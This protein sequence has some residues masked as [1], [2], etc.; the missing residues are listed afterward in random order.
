MNHPRF[1]YLLLAATIL[2]NSIAAAATLQAAAGCAPPVAGTGNVWYIDSV[3]GTALGDGSQAHPWNSLAAI[4]ETLP[5]AQAAWEPP[6]CNGDL[7]PNCSKGPLL[8]TTPYWHYDPALNAYATW[9]NPNAPIKS[10]DTILLMSGYYGDI[11]MSGAANTAFITVKPVPG[12]TPV[13]SSLN[14]NGS[15]M[16]IIQGLTFRSLASGYSAFI[17]ITGGPT[18]GSSNNII[19]DSNYLASQDNVDTWL[20]ADWNSYARFSAISTNGGPS[21][22]NAQCIAI[23]NNTIKNVRW[24]VT[25]AADNELVDGNTI[26]H[27]GDDAIDY[28]ANNLVISHNTITNNLNIGD[29]NHND[30]MQGQPGYSVA[31]TTLNNVTINGNIVIAQTTLS[32]PFPGG[33]QGIDAFDGDWSNMTVINNVVITNATHGMSFYRLHGGLIANNTVLASGINGTWLGIFDP[34]SNNV[35]VRNN[36]VSNIANDSYDPTVTFDHNLVGTQIAWWVTGQSQFLSAPGTYGNQNVIDPYGLSQVF[37]SYNKA[38]LTYDVHLLAG[39]LAVG[40]GNSVAPPD[41]FGF[42][43]PSPVDLGVFELVPPT[44]TTTTTTTTTSTTPTTT[45]TPSP[46]PGKRKGQ[47]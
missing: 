40:T 44:T 1:A 12:A 47:S 33:L 29:G 28:A 14:F 22:A 39:S 8:S 26:D 11:D 43:R 10:G 2:G 30:G 36:I 19:I 13:L 34:T 37:K 6:G 23:T 4:N 25:L 35:I 32:L 31:G 17:Q 7:G 15:A 18:Y 21:S 46:R 38:T 20:Q 3:N 24:G 16:W 45:T 9:T 42:A 41:M 5:Y 27:F